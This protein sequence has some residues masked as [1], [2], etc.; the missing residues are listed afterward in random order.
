MITNY[1]VPN[2]KVR[3]S[4]L[5]PSPDDCP[6]GAAAVRLGLGFEEKV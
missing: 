4:I 1:G 5:L 6:Q 3:R 2:W